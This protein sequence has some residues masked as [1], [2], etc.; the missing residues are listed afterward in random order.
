M[1]DLEKLY[2]E[3]EKLEQQEKE[4]QLRDL[5]ADLGIK[6]NK[7]F[8]QCVED[9]KILQEYLTV[10]QIK[11]NAFEIKKI[12]GTNFQV[13][14][15]DLNDIVTRKLLKPA[16]NFFEFFYYCKT[17][18]NG[19]LSFEQN[20]ELLGYGKNKFIELLEI[21]KKSFGYYIIMNYKEDKIP[22]D[23]GRETFIYL[24]CFKELP[25]CLKALSND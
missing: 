16:K 3:R 18:G 17:V 7:K 10:E 8:D 24:K 12:Q 4:N 13:V 22:E 25:D 23:Y 19:L 21:Y 6:V 15:K 2:K 9:I 1:L 5:C 14:F 20:Q 11:I